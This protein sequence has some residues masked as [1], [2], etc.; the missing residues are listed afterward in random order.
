LVDAAEIF[1]RASPN[2]IPGDPLF[3]DHVHPTFAGNYLLA[4]AFA[5]QI[6]NTPT[7]GPALPTAEE[8]ARRLAFTDFDCYRVLDEV[9]QRLQRPPFSD[10]FDH[11][12]RAANLKRQLERLDRASLAEAFQLYTQAIA[13]TPDDWVLREN[14]ARLLQDFDRV[15]EATE[16]WTKVMEL[17]P[18]SEQS[19]YHIGR[20]LDGAGRS[21][22]AVTYLREALRRRPGLI[23]ARLRLGAN[24][25]KM[26]R[27]DQALRELREALRVDPDNTTA[28]GL[29]AQAQAAL[30]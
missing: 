14:F 20:L 17:V 16:Q 2:G 3:Y 5:A 25:L 10:Q 7:S 23:E 19:F 21:A 13:R 9:R 22:E 11:D 12:R 18:H 24:L 26:G 27:P 30:K 8:C 15:S 6:V 4:Q 28:K 29:V 1:N